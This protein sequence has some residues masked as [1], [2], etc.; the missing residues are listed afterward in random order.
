[1]RENEKRE[2]ES[3]RRL[4]MKQRNHSL[5]CHYGIRMSVD[6]PIFCSS[7]F[8]LW[9]LSFPSLLFMT[10]V[11]C[12]LSFFWFDDSTSSNYTHML[13]VIICCIQC[14]L[15]ACTERTRA[16]HVSCLR[17]SNI[18][19]V[20][21]SRHVNRKDRW[22]VKNRISKKIRRKLYSQKSV[23][24]VPKSTWSSF[25]RPVVCM[26]RMIEQFHPSVPVSVTIHTNKD[27]I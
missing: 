12:F 18:N 19:A 2:R 5:S 22:Q 26:K 10:G 11:L 7:S 1:M 3:F 15:T 9:Q 25:Q 16:K 6:V 23:T 17:F 4:T 8:F 20:R 13:T 21:L 24:F 27:E 14:T